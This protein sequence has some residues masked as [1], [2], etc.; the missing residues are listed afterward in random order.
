LRRLSLWTM[1][2]SGSYGSTY[3]ESERGLKIRVTLGAI[4]F[5]SSVY[6]ACNRGL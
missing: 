6:F 1:L 4:V 3:Y 2:A 5:Y